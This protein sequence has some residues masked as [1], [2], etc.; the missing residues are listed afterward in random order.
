[1][2]EVELGDSPIIWVQNKK[3]SAYSDSQVSGPSHWIVDLL[4]HMTRCLDW[5]PK[6]FGHAQ[7]EI[8][9]AD[10]LEEKVRTGLD[11]FWSSSEQSEKI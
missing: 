2:W 1:M 9:P 8:P 10:V 4:N 6:G 3:G 5:V 11:L 7:S